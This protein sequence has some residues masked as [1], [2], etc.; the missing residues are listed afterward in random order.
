MSSP[1]T[2][3]RVPS[4]N[5][6]WISGTAALFCYAIHA[7]FHLLHGRPYDLLWACHIGAAIV[8]VGL[9]ASSATV[10]GIGTLF[11]WLGTPLWLMEV[12]G[13]HEEFNPTS[14]FTHV[15]GL[16][17]GL[18]GTY[19]LGMP[20]GVWWKAVA[21]LV[22][23]IGLCRLTT[24]ASANVNVAFAIP[25]GWEGQFA[26]HGAYLITVIGLVAGYFLITQL[27]LRLA[28]ALLKRQSRSQKSGAPGLE[29]RP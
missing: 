20:K 9:L 5:P 12:A 7:G 28:L 21:V 17:L 6:A 26:S 25:S 23:L 4:L 24:P 13:G 3:G 29:E 19:R 14:C 10:N 1:K 11:L 15:G 22:G 27:V 2:P 18:Y 16:V 8:G